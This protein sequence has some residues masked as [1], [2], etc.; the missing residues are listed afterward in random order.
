MRPRRTVRFGLVS[1]MASGLYYQIR[2]TSIFSYI[3]QLQQNFSISI[4]CYN[5]LAIDWAPD[6]ILPFQPIAMD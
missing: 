1:V 3:H 4:F 6:L 2:N 5:L